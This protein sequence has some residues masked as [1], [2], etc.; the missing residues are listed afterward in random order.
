M[1]KETKPDAIAPEAAGSFFMHL[2][3]KWNFISIPDSETITKLSEELRLSP[4][5]VEILMKRGYSTQKQIQI[6]LNP[7]LR[8]IR[9]PYLLRNMPEAVELLQ[10]AIH[11]DWNILILGDYDVDGMTG[12]AIM[13]EF[14]EQCGCTNLDFF[15]PNRLQH[16]YGLTA[17]STEIILQRKPDLLITVDN[18]ISSFDEIRTLHQA[19]IQTLITDHHLADAQRLPEGI[20]LNPSHPE[21]NY[22]FKEI[23]GCGVALKLIMGIRKVLR[24]EGWWTQQRPEPN[25]KQCL[26]L[27]ALGTVAD[28]VSLTDENRILVHHGLEVMNNSPRL[29][30]RILKHLQK[31]SLITSRSLGFQFAPLLNAAGRLE[32]ASI[33]V[34]LLLSKDAQ[35]CE[36]MVKHLQGVNQERRD[37]EAEM[38]QIAL[39][40]AE[41]Q[42]KRCSLVIVS[43]HFHEGVNGIVASRIVE[44]FHK[45]TLIFSK[46]EDAYK[47]SARSIPEVHIKDALNECSDLL[48]RFGGHSAA[49]GCSLPPKNFEAFSLKFEKVCA[50]M[51]PQKPVP[52]L[53]LVGH[54]KYSECNSQLLNQLEL[55]EPFGEGNMEPVFAVSAPEIPFTTLKE[56]H[57]KWKLSGGSEILGWNYVEHF[58]SHPPKTL[59]VILAYNRFRGNKTLQMT[60]RDA[61]HD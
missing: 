5:I 38:L 48:G 41:E 6:F 34:K 3:K 2:K 26:D 53:E 11:E 24:E 30:I 44:R 35:E 18:G 45:P 13:L 40:Q 14:L 32:D 17:A 49:A 61:H 7:S 39:E 31:V 52:Q 15:I 21:C 8:D 46:R 10:K 36:R 20:I 22:P 12:T 19:E 16:G 28:V 60:I 43:E 33:A 54:L 50:E 23:S 29:A 27:A 51:L 4:L 56:K 59:A 1:L 57:V 25:L 47:G 9:D 55:L 37:K 58:L 42:Q